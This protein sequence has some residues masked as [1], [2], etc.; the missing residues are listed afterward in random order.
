[1]KPPQSELFAA[2]QL[3]PASVLAL[4]AAW[5]VPLPV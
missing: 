4:V 3:Q 1:M 5:R 2:A